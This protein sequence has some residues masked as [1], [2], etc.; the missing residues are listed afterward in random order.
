VGHQFAIPIATCSRADNKWGPLL[1][2]GI[3][4]GLGLSTFAYLK[5]RRASKEKP[6]LEKKDY[7]VAYGEFT[8]RLEKMKTY[9]E[10][11]QI[12]FTKS[13]NEERRVNGLIIIDAYFGLD[14]HI[15]EIEAH[16]VNY[17]LPDN[18]TDYYSR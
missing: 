5:Y 7:M 15:R 10:E 8:K 6:L 17:E 3:F 9:L 1:S 4:A 18:I 13:Q 14:I 11:N 2:L 16:L 12:F